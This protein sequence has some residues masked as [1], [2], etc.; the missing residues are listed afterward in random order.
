MVKFNF[1]SNVI[2]MSVTTILNDKITKKK[3]NESLENNANIKI[4]T[5]YI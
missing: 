4:T 1:Q 5:K 2:M 3:G